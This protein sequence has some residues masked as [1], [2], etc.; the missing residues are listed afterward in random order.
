MLRSNIIFMSTSLDGVAM[1]CMQKV[2]VY[3]KA[4]A[5]CSLLKPENNVHSLTCK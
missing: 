5:F 4:H 2:F 1:A 3:M